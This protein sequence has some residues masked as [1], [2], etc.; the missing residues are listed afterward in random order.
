MAKSIFVRGIWVALLHSNEQL[1]LRSAEVVDLTSCCVGPKEEDMTDREG[2][3]RLADEVCCMKAEADQREEE[4]RQ[5]KENLEA[6]TVEWDESWCQV[7]EASICIDSLS[8]H[9]KVERSEG[10]ALKA[11][12]GGILPKPYLIFRFDLLFLATA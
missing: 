4:M 10:Q 8:K 6:V 12:I 9:L 2:M 11:W 7:V 1:A 5:M 3:H